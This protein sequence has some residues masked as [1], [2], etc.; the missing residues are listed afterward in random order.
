VK[1]A[2]ATLQIKRLAD[3]PDHRVLTGIASTPEPDRRG[4][5]IELDGLTFAN[6]IP[7]LLHHDREKPIGTVTL[8]K[9]A[10][11]LLFEAAIPLIEKAGALRDRIEEALDSVA[12]GLIG[13][14]SIGFRTFEDGIEFLKTGGIKFTKAEVLELSLV[15][16]PANARATIEHVKSWDA[17]TLAAFGRNTP[18]D[19]GSLPVVSRTKDAPAMPPT[20]AEQITQWS[21]TRA[22][23]AARVAEL[24]EK[25]HAA[26]VTLD[27]AQSEEYDTLTAEIRSIDTHLG[28]LREQEAIGVGAATRIEVPA[29]PEAG[30]ALR[31]GTPQSPVIQVI[32]RS[33]PGIRFAR[34]A[35]CL[36]TAKGF[37]PQA[38]E[39]AK[40]RYPD[41]MGIQTVLKAAVAAGTT[42][43]PTWAGALIDYTNFAGDFIEYLR[44]LTIVG[45]F[46]QDGI[47]SLTR[48]PFNVRII[49]QTSGGSGYWVGQGKAKPL[50][51]VDFAPVTLGWAK[52]A[53]IAVI[54]EELARFNSPSAETLV[55]N[56]LSAA[57]VERID[58]DFVDPA[59][60][61]VAN[62]SPASITNGVT[63]VVSVGT[64]AAAIAADLAGLFA[65]FLAANNPPSS[66]VFIMSSTLALKLSLVTNA[67]GVRLYPDIS[68]MGG[69]FMGLPVITSNYVAANVVILVNASDIYLADDGTVTIDASREASLEMSDAPAG[70]AAAGTGA[71]LVSMFQTDSVALRAERF[72]NWAKRRPSSVQYLS[73]VDWTGTETP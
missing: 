54:T 66:G 7:L 69:R 56:A 19:S 39:I 67:D 34:Y 29:K 72:I 13:G 9:S 12:L 47:P 68:M 21:N 14:V 71:S 40:N 20:F 22:P 1:R 49:G 8:S 10:R 11:A 63:P 41:D 28:R 73:D 37:A 48:V 52:V 15:T 43:D 17:E 33:E 18:G 23:K 27:A 35:M 3:E 5:V 55:R 51:K 16:I 32:T 25:A 46:G 60:A 58:R 50:T 26:G 42:T 62:V 30:A 36:I 64:D 38:L 4:D 59:K 45:K 31:G 44:P 61:A 65:P 2:Y 57:L 6:P 70:D 53:N 24:M